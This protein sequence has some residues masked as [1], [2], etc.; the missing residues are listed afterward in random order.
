M[1]RRRGLA[2]RIYVG[3]AN[4]L[5]AHTS[6]ESR[7]AFGFWNIVVALILAVPF[8][9]AVLYVTCLSIVALFPNVTSETPVEPE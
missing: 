4:W 9:R 8:G 5:V 1:A 6:A 7:R 3:P 2:W